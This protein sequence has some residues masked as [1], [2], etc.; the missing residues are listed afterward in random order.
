M[1]DPFGDPSLL[2]EEVPYTSNPKLR[3]ISIVLYV[4]GADYR[5]STAYIPHFEPTSPHATP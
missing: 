2:P 4:R 1:S 3:V 5:V